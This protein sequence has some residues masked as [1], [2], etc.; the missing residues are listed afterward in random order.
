MQDFCGFRFA[1]FALLT[2]K[3]KLNL[4]LSEQRLLRLLLRKAFGEV[5]ASIFIDSSAAKEFSL[6]AQ[7]AE[8]NSNPG[9]QALL[10]QAR[11]QTLSQLTGA[12]F[13]C[14]TGFKGLGKT[15]EGA[16]KTA[17]RS[18]ARI[19][20]K[21]KTAALGQSRTSPSATQSL[22]E[23]MLSWKAEKNAYRERFTP[24]AA[25]ANA[26]PS[27]LWMSS[28]QPAHFSSNLMAL[29]ATTSG[30]DLHAALEMVDAGSFN[31]EFRSST[32]TKQSWFRIIGGVLKRLRTTE[33]ALLAILLA[34]SI[35]TLSLPFII[36]GKMVAN[37]IGAFCVLVVVTSMLRLLHF[38]A[39]EKP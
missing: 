26:Y 11:M 7:R 12:L 4:W 10:N 18:L 19:A 38:D 17:I 23:T 22:L 16:M 5:T 34:L 35:F 1:D 28:S 36:V 27:F 33:K 32:F 25:A 31:G 24:M 21:E 14:Q 13:Y 37:T 29:V 3:G 8:K 20:E 6:F 9:K 30:T 2:W 39:S 15:L